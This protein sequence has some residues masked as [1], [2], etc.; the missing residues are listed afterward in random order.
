MK[1]VSH[2]GWLLLTSIATLLNGQVTPRVL[3][4]TVGVLNATE[5]YKWSVM[6][7]ENSGRASGV[8]VGP[9][10]YATAA[11]VVFDHDTLAWVK[12]SLLKAY[13]CN[14]SISTFSLSRR[15]GVATYRWEG[16]ITRNEA[17]GNSGANSIDTFNL[18]FAAVMVSTAL[19]PDGSFAPTMVDPPD[20][21]QISF[22]RRASV[23]TIIGY[24][25][26]SDYVEST[27]IGKMHQNAP[28]NYETHWLGAFDDP[29][30]SEGEWMAVH[31]LTD[32]VTYRGNSG[33]PVYG[34]D[35][36]DRWRLNAILVGGNS[37]DSAVR[38]I[39]EAAWELIENANAASGGAPVQRVEGLTTSPTA[40]QVELNWED[41]SDGET[42]YIVERRA[43]AGWISVA[44][45]PADTHSWVDPEFVPGGVFTYR[46]TPRQGDSLV[47]PPS[48]WVTV[49]TPG[50]HPEIGAAL[51][52]PLLSFQTKG[53]AP[54]FVDGGV[55]S[56][57]KI[58]GMETSELELELIGP[59]E[60]RFS[61][62]VSSENNP[63]YNNSSSSYYGD[64]YDAFFF[65][66]D[67]D[68]VEFI[69]GYVGPV[70]KTINVPAGAHT[71][72]WKYS[73]DPYSDEGEDRGKLHALRWTPTGS[74]TP[75]YGARA[76]NSEIQDAVWFGPY[77][78][79]FFPWVYHFEL[80]WLYF[81][82]VDTEA[83]WCYSL[84]SQLGWM[85]IRAGTFPFIYSA[86]SDSW[87]F[88]D[89]GSAED[90][91]GGWF[92]D[93]GTNQWVYHL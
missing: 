69:S 23:K 80:G 34:M 33:C 92:Y 25:A 31:Y 16:Y 88:Y 79:L 46:V 82:P 76:I 22:L 8:V 36:V 3:T 19:I 4:E 21:D 39:D 17:D 2:S 89:R 48:R 29:F 67:G 43:E 93:Y 20:I 65:E 28:G 38:G 44:E 85:Y 15:L 45:L 70:E 71:F 27:N 10:T 12:P 9:R 47:A 37:S 83:F 5:P 42:A 32:V 35:S 74:N 75:V 72:R 52:E 81:V 77:S 56:S 13:W 51:G 58:W 54:M 14:H 62:S 49:E 40:D 1:T 68:Q 53:D 30:D 59:G 73:K 87:L 7:L 55:V 50:V 78:V 66:Q 86:T 24:P 61:W 57:G 18:D 60:L 63:D 11:H 6:V 84:D 91:H 64:I 26:D 41:R 90:G